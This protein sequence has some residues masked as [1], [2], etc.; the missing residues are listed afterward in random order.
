M[1]VKLKAGLGD[2]EWKN[3]WKEKQSWGKR[4]LSTLMYHWTWNMNLE[5]KHTESKMEIAEK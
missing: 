2:T 1:G 5:G 3:T 4:D